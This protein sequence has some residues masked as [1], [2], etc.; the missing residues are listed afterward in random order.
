MLN[1]TSP[2]ALEQLYDSRRLLLFKLGSS[3][4]SAIVAI[5]AALD[6]WRG[7]TEIGAWLAGFALVSFGNLAVHFRGQHLNRGVWILDATIVLLSFY[8]VNSGGLGG[9]G[10]FWVFPMLI[11]ML[12]IHSYRRSALIGALFITACAL[13]LLTP[14]ATLLNNDYPPHVA[15]RIVMTLFATY[16]LTMFTIKTLDQI[17]HALRQAHQSD[18]RSLSYYDSLTGLPNRNYFRQELFEALS[19]ARGSQNQ[20]AVIYIDL[21]KFK[22]INEMHG[23]ELGD[24]L[25]SHFAQQL[26]SIIE[27]FSKSTYGSPGTVARLAGDEFVIL[28]K[29]LRFTSQLSVISQEI[30]DLFTDGF[31]FEDHKYHLQA[32]AGSAI[33]PGDTDEADKLL[34]YSQAAM[35]NAKA[36]G[37]N[38]YQA[39]SQSIA[40]EITRQQQVEN[41][42]REALE[43]GA[44]SLRFMPIFDCQTRAITG[45]E[46]L[47]RTEHPA[48]SGIG[49]DE[50]IPVAERT[51]LI[52]NID[53]WVIESAFAS[54]QN[55]QQQHGFTGLMCINI[56]SLEL[57]NEQFVDV[58]A[59]LLE[60]SKLDPER[61]EIEITETAMVVDGA[62]SVE[63]LQQLRELGIT[64]AL[65]DFGTGYTAFSQLINFPVDCL[66]IDRSFVD[67][68][69]S[70]SAERQKM[71][72]I[73]MKLAE[74]YNL[75]VIAEGVETQAQLDYL[76]AN[77]CDWCQ[78]YLLSK[79][80]TL[81]QLIDLL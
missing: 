33:F 81:K 8:L 42:L 16:V 3:F 74:I 44:F 75:R 59:E 48:L 6:S 28:L 51:G 21:D 45:V 1:I 31:L 78:G 41:G 57:H 29:D 30:I 20:V 61:I 66:K 53:L 24:S 70:N 38:R 4:G 9:T 5:L 2:K 79:P 69:F 50:F 34:D 58:F 60:R 27:R 46:V 18:V 23:H 49:P 11:I 12:S 32:A 76:A 64:L 77:G 65:D 62:G 14:V 7:N 80:L 26:E 13:V 73:I 22:N 17:Y 40:A 47:L 67:G 54:L 35:R 25:L 71:V 15:S 63:T 68:L 72:P 39:F 56:S 10:V 43:I 36:A 37:D 19:A 52:K 55:L